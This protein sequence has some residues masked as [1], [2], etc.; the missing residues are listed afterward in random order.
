M[1]TQQRKKLLASVALALLAQILLFLPWPPPLSPWIE[2]GALLL[3]AVF[4]PGH[5]L[6]EVV[7]RDFGAPATR[8]EWGVYAVGGGY[9]L[10][11]VLML[12]LS[13]LPGPL[14][15]WALHAGV[16]LALVALVVAAWPVAGEEAH[17]TLPLPRW[18]IVALLVV[19]ALATVLRL[20]NLGYAEYHGD[21]ARAVLRAAAVI[22]GY[23][24]VLFL[25]KKGPAEILIPTALFAALGNL[26][27]SAARLPFAFANVTAVAAVY[28]LGRRLFGS[29]AGLSA[30]LLLA[31]DGFF[32]GFARIVQYQSIVI[33]MSALTLLVLVRLWQSPR[34]MWRA[35]LLAA[36]FLATGLWAHYEAGMAAIPAL[37]LLGLLWMRHRDQRRGLLIGF[38]GAVILGSVLLVIF[39]LPFLQHEQFSATYTYLVD[40]RIGGDGFPTNNVADLWL[41]LTTYSSSYYGLTLIALLLTALLTLYWRVLSRWT[42]L[43]ASLLLLTFVAITAINPTWAT[44]AGR[45]WWVLVAALFLLPAWLMPRTRPE[46]RLVWIWY[47]AI[48][49]IMV[50]FTSKP[51]THVYTFFTPWALLAG[52]VVQRMG[53][54]WAARSAWQRQRLVWAGVAVALGAALIFGGYVY[55]VF[56]VTRVEVLRTWQVNWPRGYWRPYAVLDNDALFGFPLAN[57][58]KAIGQLYADGTL[59]GDYATNEIEYWTPIWY[60]HG[61]MRCDARAEYFFQIQNFQSNPSDYQTAL[62]LQLEDRGFMPWA[63]VTINGEPRLL[64]RQRGD[65][66]DMLQ[67]FALEE[68][69]AAFDVAATPDLPL[70]YPV[71][72][73]PIEHP[74]D[75]NFGGMIRLE[76]FDL[77][78]PAPLQPGSQITLTLYWRA[79]QKID[80][81][82]K[83][84]NQAYYGDGV[85]VAQQDGYPVCGG[86]GTWQWEPGVQV[87]DVHLLTILPDTP[88]GLYPLYTGLYIEETFERLAVVDENGQPITDRAHLTD[89]RVGEE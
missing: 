7:G 55:Q 25:H 30:A 50:G 20:T 86:R 47:G 12:L 84:F 60:T 14:P 70:G 19:L 2:V 17:P 15:W 71:V 32:I 11:L 87:A 59:S 33:L 73:P 69:A 49:I 40:R 13:Y 65:A 62:E 88:D 23:D 3:W 26:T 36:L 77:D 85:M 6:V 79:L 43:A 42:A 67:S 82:Y 53:N 31:L 45:D 83:V 24:D 72:E 48:F 22:Q 56:A 52:L 10:L 66:A 1:L 4:I 28:W 16:D 68:Y 81:S 80:A 57:G 35:L 27:E 76:G 38:G 37:F 18:E 78:A 51:R 63:H 8:L 44:V 21:E 64:I 34:A 75:I 41:R 5:L 29:I 39:Y 61:R 46:E 74:L 54:A 89:L 9:A 58:W